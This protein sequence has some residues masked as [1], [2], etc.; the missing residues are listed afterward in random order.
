MYRKVMGCLSSKQEISKETTPYTK[1]KQ[2]R[3]RCI[4]GFDRAKRIEFN[5]Q[6]GVA[7]V[8]DESLNTSHRNPSRITPSFYDE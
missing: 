3:L 8:G 6:F 5:A 2:C 1:I 4:A 7:H